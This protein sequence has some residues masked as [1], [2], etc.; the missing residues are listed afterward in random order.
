MRE[1]NPAGT[2]V[3]AERGAG[4]DK[5]TQQKLLTAQERPMVE[6]AIPACCLWV[7]YISTCSYRLGA[8]ADEPWKR[9]SPWTAPHGSSLGL[10]L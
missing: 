2:K 6:Q 5:G 7:Q 10:E 3:S 9:Y 8:A 4:G 1:T